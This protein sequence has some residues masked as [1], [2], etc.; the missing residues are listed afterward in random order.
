MKKTKLGI[1]VSNRYGV[2]Y[3]EQV[4]LLARIGFDAVSPT[5][6]K[7]GSHGEIIE[8]ARACGLDVHF[9]HARFGLVASMWS[10]D[11]EKWM[12]ALETQLCSLEDCRR[13]GIPI[14]VAHTWIGFGDEVGDVEAGL[15]HYDIL[16]ERA[17][18][19]GVQIA[20]ENTE[21]LPYLEALMEHY[22]GNDTVGFCWDSGHEMCYNGSEDLLERF[23]DRLYVTHLNDNLGVSDPN[24]KIYWTDD[25]HL[26]P[27]DGILDWEDAAVRLRRARKL[28]VLNFELK[29]DSIP[30]R[31]ENDPYERMTLEEYF[32]E[33]YRRAGRIAELYQG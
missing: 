30:G 18:A 12:A 14:M 8:A 13:Y 23:G 29:R 5:W 16:V 11:E 20:F 15:K 32:T 24:G 19:Y 26:L 1:S 27:E 22:R 31:H 6:Q 25:L 28:D 3:A 21:G 7:D 17:K 33:A 2:T 4:E 10:A 9:M